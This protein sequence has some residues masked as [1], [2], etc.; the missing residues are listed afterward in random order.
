MLALPD[1]VRRELARV[2]LDGHPAETCGVLVGR[3]SADGAVVERM[4]PARNLN[5]DRAHDRYELDPSDFLQ[6][7]LQARSDGLEVVGIWHSHPD[8]PAEPSETDRRAAWEGWSY[9]ILAVSAGGVGDW[10]SW[11]LEGGQRFSEEPLRKEVL[12]S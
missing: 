3:R 10:R 12:S 9:L 11:R 7:D 4:V 8:H 5:V 1:D 2:A 6:A